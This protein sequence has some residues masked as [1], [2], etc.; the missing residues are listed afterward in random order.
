MGH[1][2]SAG[3]GLTEYKHLAVEDPAD[4][5]MRIIEGIHQAELAAAAAAEAAA[6]AGNRRGAGGRGRR[7]ALRLRVLGIWNS[8]SCGGGGALF[9]LCRCLS[10]SWWICDRMK[11]E[12]HPVILLRGKPFAVSPSC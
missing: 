6:L 12:F 11:K 9:F 4:E 1:L 10:P 5:D 2:I 8:A 3:T 7:I